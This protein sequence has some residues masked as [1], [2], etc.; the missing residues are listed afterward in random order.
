MSQ[1]QGP[2]LPLTTKTIGLLGSVA[3]GKSALAAMFGKLGATV[4]D[5]DR[6]AHEVL[7]EP[8]IVAQVR[9]QWGESMLD[10]QGQVDRGKLA[11][12][13]FQDRGEIDKLNAII[14]PRVI[15]RVQQR[16]AEAQ[17]RGAPA[18]V[19]DVPLLA[20]RGLADVCD[21]LIYIDTP[22]ARRLEQSK[23]Q[24]GWA[25]DELARRDALQMP[26]DQKRRLAQC[27]VH[28]DGS[29]DELFE[30]AQAIWAREIAPPRA[31]P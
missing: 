2:Q 25:D 1:A 12:V 23:R 11:D 17:R 18:V 28:N 3:S 24:R 14:H 20:E 15:E 8:D 16:Q 27:V 13:V 9:G 29:L 10:A 5:A 19:L 30:Q 31:K 21:L 7:C 22:R 6:L 4:I 26:A